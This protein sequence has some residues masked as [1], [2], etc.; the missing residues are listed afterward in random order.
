MND[1]DYVED[2]L[3]GYCDQ[4]KLERKTTL[5]KYY[6]KH[7]DVSGEFAQRVAYSR[8][9]FDDMHDYRKIL[10]EQNISRDTWSKNSEDVFDNFLS[11]LK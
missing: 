4:N 3:N 6:V 7:K 10:S 1:M 11:K 2:L 8:R 5:I 9:E